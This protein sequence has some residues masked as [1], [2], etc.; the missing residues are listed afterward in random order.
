MWRVSEIRLWAGES[1]ILLLLLTLL[2][3][4]G[5]HSLPETCELFWTADLRC[6]TQET[7]LMRMTTPLMP[8]SIHTI[9]LILQWLIICLMFVNLFP[10]PSI[11]QALTE[12]PLGGTPIRTY[13]M[14]VQRW[15]ESI[16][17]PS[18]VS[19]LYLTPI[20]MRPLQAQL[21]CA[22]I[23]QIDMKT[24]KCAYVYFGHLNIRATVS[25]HNK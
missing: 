12:P 21:K 15:T 2:F 9:H 25:C 1:I 18:E 23:I 7:L 17:W 3:Q 19:A 13:A 24:S 14:K 16:S 4:Y 11:K 10:Q 6:Q 5:E 8:A 22:C 20:C